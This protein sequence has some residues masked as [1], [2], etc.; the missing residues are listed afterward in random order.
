MAEP[1]ARQPGVADGGFGLIEFM[2]V[3]AIILILAAVAVPRYRSNYVLP[4]QT[5]E[6]AQMAAVIINAMN[7][8]AGAM[9][10]SPQAAQH[11]FN[12]TVLSLDTTSTPAPPPPPPPPGGGPAPPPPPPPPAPTSALQNLT[13]YLPGLALPIGATFDYTV[14]AAVANNGPEQGSTVYCIL[15]TGRSTAGNPG[16]LAAYSSSPASAAASGWLGRLNDNA[17]VQDNA[18]ALS[19]GGYC[20]N[21]GQAQPTYQ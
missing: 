21:K 15:A 8:Y 2:F 17:Y 7:G 19:A 20:N 18:T 12:H 9:S 3:A 16:G 14:S 5:A 6:A 13:T 11:L 1:H 4:N 10:L